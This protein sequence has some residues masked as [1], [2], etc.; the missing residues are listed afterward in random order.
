[1]I[2]KKRNMPEIIDIVAL[3]QNNPLTRLTS[4]YGSKIIKKIQERFNQEDQQLFVANFY[5]YLNYNQKTDFVVN[6]DRIWKW[7]GY[8]RISF[9]KTLLL[10]HFKENIDY[11]IEKAASED[12]EA[13]PKLS[14][15]GKNLG[16]A[17]LNREY[18]TLTVNCFKKL[19]L[20]ARTEKADQIHDYYIQ[21]EELMNELVQEQT[22]ELQKKL[23]LKDT[24]LKQE[25]EKVYKLTGKKLREHSKGEF[26]Y[27]Y[28]P[29]PDQ[30][31]YKIGT[32]IN[33]NQRENTY[34]CSNPLG[35]FIYERHCPGSEI[36][37][38]TIHLSLN[39]FRI[40]SSREHFKG[41]VD[42]FIKKIDNIINIV[43]D[44]EPTKNLI[45]LQPIVLFD[46][47]K[48][49]NIIDFIK[50]C[51]ELNE[52]YYCIKKEIP[53]AYKIWSKNNNKENLDKVQ[54]YFES[55]FKKGKH[56]FEDLE[57]STL[58][59]YNGIRLKN[60][61]LYDNNIFDKF[62]NEECKFSPLNRIDKKTLEISFIKY[63][64]IDISTIELTKFNEYLNNHKYIFNNYVML[65]THH[66]DGYWGIQLKNDK[67]NYGVKVSKSRRKN[68]ICTKDIEV[69]KF[70]SLTE[71]SRHFKVGIA[72]LT[73]DI[74]LN[75]IRN[76]YIITSD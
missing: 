23:Q 26:I 30:D 58:A 21:L 20:K 8:S 29:Y 44:D 6:L 48:K 13:G 57:N 2:S 28:K 64:K 9:C 55:T 51:C 19:C 53:A 38:K 71:A 36:V 27:I 63:R 7:L 52:S 37:E 49:D 35:K 76:G 74:K 1:M 3:V 54:K 39:K 40:T 12:A 67:N 14:E 15:E 34:M 41:S 10:K 75:R 68:V 25:Q 33:L 32:T 62:L 4:S 5:C 61:E 65:N 43:L 72:S 16:G 42:F 69:L 24:E 22:Q 60:Y 11:K 18:I 46:Q 47:I 73:L 70:E 50:E 45:D 31:D 59:I 17:G 56:F 66:V